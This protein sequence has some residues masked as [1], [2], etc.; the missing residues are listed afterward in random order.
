M[1]LNSHWTLGLCL[2]ACETRVDCNLEIGSRWLFWWFRLTGQERMAD[3]CWDA[4]IGGKGGWSGAVKKRWWTY[5]GGW[6]GGWGLGPNGRLAVTSISFGGRHH[7][8][9]GAGKNSM[10]W[11]DLRSLHSFLRQ[12]NQ[13]GWQGQQAWLPAPCSSFAAYKWSLGFC[14]CR[15]IWN[16]ANAPDSSSLRQRY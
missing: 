15:C 2:A 5:L 1:R 16:V 14:V 7:R 12:L 11:P 3:E 4:G 9:V 10:S 6:V 8:D 13:E